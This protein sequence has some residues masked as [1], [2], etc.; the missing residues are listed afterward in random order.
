MEP[1]QPNQQAPHE[2]R[3]PSDGSLHRVRPAKENLQVTA[4]SR[5]QH[6]QRVPDHATDDGA[7]E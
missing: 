2:K 3:R 5:P 4:K 7:Q 6:R 1:V